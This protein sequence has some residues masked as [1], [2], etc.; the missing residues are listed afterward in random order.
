MLYLETALKIG[1]G[2][3]GVVVSAFTA[4]IDELRF[5][6]LMEARG[7]VSESDEGSIV[8]AVFS[9]VVA[10]N[11]CNCVDEGETSSEAGGY[12][13]AVSTGGCS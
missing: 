1:V 3:A 2:L 4:P 6:K 11:I 7:S 12:C 9:G 13:S 5:A 8:C 10:S